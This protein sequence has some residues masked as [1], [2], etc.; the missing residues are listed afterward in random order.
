MFGWEKGLLREVWRKWRLK[1]T[2]ILSAGDGNGGAITRNI[3]K[4]VHN[5]ISFEYGEFFYML[6]KQWE[7]PEFF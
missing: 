3:G 1:I 4:K 5:E 2:L 6:A 7:C